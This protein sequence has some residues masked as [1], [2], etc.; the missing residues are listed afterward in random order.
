MSESQPTHGIA[1][2]L[3]LVADDEPAIR[4]IVSRM[5]VELDLVPVLVGD[6]AAAIAAVEAHQ[7]ELACAILDIA[8][9]GANGVDAAHVIQL[10]APNVALM[11]TSGAIPANCAGRI[12]RLRLVG[13]LQKPFPLAALRTLIRQ[14]IADSGAR[15]TLMETWD[16]QPHN[17]AQDV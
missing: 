14:A 9:P 17:V 15:G 6:G 5:L 16:A 12:T 3:V 4:A 13:I 11:L 1:R 7:S 10:I 8:M 2:T